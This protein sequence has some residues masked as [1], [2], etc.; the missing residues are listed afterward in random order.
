M[1][2]KGGGH[3]NV[4][5]L[6]ITPEPSSQYDQISFQKLLLTINHNTSFAEAE[7]CTFLQNDASLFNFVIEF[8]WHYAD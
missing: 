7:V 4:F 5:E 1:V 2:L 3:K 6:Y 8:F